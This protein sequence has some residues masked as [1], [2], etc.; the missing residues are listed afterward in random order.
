M[1]VVVECCCPTD[2]HGIA[3]SFA[4]AE[5][6]EQAEAET[7]VHQRHEVISMQMRMPAEW[8]PSGSRG[9]HCR[10]RWNSNGH[11]VFL[12]SQGATVT[13]PLKSMESCTVSSVLKCCMTI[14]W[15]DGVGNVVDSEMSATSH[16]LLHG[17]AGTI[18]ESLR[19]L[20]LEQQ[21]AGPL[22]PIEPAA[23]NHDWPPLSGPLVR[24]LCV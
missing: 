3:H 5:E 10:E 15:T 7:V 18:L 22:M 16:A 1:S 14:R 6:Y 12:T 23:A 21:D 20:R 19:L 8:K 4:Y 11:V 2:H 13:I 17:W 9:V 24:S